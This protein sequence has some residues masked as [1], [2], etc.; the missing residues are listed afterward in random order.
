MIIDANQMLYKDL[1]NSIRESE[2]KEVVVNNCFGQRYIGCALNNKKITVNGTPGNALGAYLDG[3]EVHIFGNAQD[4]TG[5]TMNDGK[6][7][8]HG[9][10]G[11]AAG[12]SMRGGK[13][14]IKGNAGY[15]AGIHMKAYKEKFPVL[16]IGGNAGSFLAEYQAGGL[17]L[18]LGLNDNA[19][20]V[21]LMCG[22]G[23]HGGKVI[24]R[25]ENLPKSLPQQV[26]HR[27]AKAEDLQEIEGYVKE[28]CNEFGYDFDTVMSHKFIVLY[29]DSKHPYKQLYTNN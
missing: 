11:D 4:A 2:D 5:D 12:Y 27:V 21:G 6:I 1:N 24:I 25:S 29:P 9:N 28:F 26:A 14:L 10:C 13:I 22:T 16:V 7:I 15:R 17:I 20:K 8:I 19:E 18:V 3:A 23:M